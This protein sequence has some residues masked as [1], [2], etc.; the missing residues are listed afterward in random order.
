MSRR[1][2]LCS[3]SNRQNTIA[4]FVKSKVKIQKSKPKN[5]STPL[6]IGLPYHPSVINDMGIR[7]DSVNINFS[8][9]KLSKRTR[10]ALIITV[11]FA[12][13]LI[14]LSF[15]TEYVGYF[16]GECDMCGLEY[17]IT[18]DQLVLKNPLLKSKETIHIINGDFSDLKFNAPL[19]LLTNLTRTF[20][21]PDCTDGGGF[22]LGFKFLGM[23]FKF[24]FDRNSE[25]WYFKGMADIVKSRMQRIEIIEA[26][27]SKN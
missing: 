14:R 2:Q 1:H 26:A 25:P 21:C 8:W 23:D 7:E 16:A 6:S 3:G 18:N 5:I 4:F 15:T 13:S 24:R 11:L 12:L 20:G 22:I 17:T 9:K 19:L 27:Q 10:V